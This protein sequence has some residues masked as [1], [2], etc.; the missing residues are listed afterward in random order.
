MPREQY[1]R[2]NDDPRL[3]LVH[4]WM[5]AE[6]MRNHLRE[7][8]DSY[9]GD[10]SAAGEEQG[11]EFTTYLAFWLS[12]LFV[13]VEGFNKSKLKDARIQRLFT[14][15]LHDLKAMRHETFHFIPVR[16]A[17]GHRVISKMSWA[18][19]LHDA[20]GE[21]LSE[22]AKEEARK[23]REKARLNRKRRSVGKKGKV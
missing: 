18:S 11:Y 14:E 20:I 4:Y 13:V 16:E 19:E 10:V 17:Y 3:R 7:L 2:F 23:E 8:I 1:K 9:D 12:A 5:S 21:H 6:I 15:H 22:V